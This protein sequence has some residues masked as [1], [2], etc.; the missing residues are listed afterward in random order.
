M[1]PSHDPAG[2]TMVDSV[3]I[4]IKSKE[5]FGWPDD[6]DEALEASAAVRS[7]APATALPTS[8]VESP[9]T[10]AILTPVDK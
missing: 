6:A 7:Q 2:I 4:F 5:S 3:K 10:N 8:D 9:V 1:G